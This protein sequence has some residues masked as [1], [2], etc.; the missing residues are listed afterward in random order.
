VHPD[1]KSRFA[2]LTQEEKQL[3]PADVVS[4][5][6]LAS[7]ANY[8]APE[9]IRFERMRRLNETIHVVSNKLGALAT[10]SKQ[11]AD[12]VFLDILFEQA[13]D[14]FDQEL[15]QAFDSA[16]KAHKVKT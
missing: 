6:T 10:P 13:G 15:A 1:L 11:Y 7:R 5:L 16:L 12:D 14:A 2:G 9:A 3:V 4:A 8:D